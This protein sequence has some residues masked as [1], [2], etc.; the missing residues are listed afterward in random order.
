M[1]PAAATD[2]VKQVSPE[3]WGSGLLVDGLH[4]YGVRV[5]YEDTDAGGIVYHSCYMNYA[6]RARTE[7]LRCLGLEQSHLRREFGLLF[8]VRDCRIEFM[9]PARFDDVLEIRTNFLDLKGAALRAH[10]EIWC[11]GD[12]LVTV[13]SRIAAVGENGRPMRIPVA[14]SDVMRV[15]GIAPAE[16][17]VVSKE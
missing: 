12:C 1:K 11:G 10:Q 8:T 13:D 2:Q 7:Y 6:E 16:A 4:R 3:I 15:G 5:Y 17:Q 14:L 9:R